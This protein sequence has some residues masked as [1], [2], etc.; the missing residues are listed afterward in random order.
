MVFYNFLTDPLELEDIS[1][2]AGSP[3]YLIE[4]L[5]EELALSSLLAHTVTSAELEASASTSL[6]LS[7]FAFTSAD[8]EASTTNLLVVPSIMIVDELLAS[9]LLYTSPSPRDQ[10]GSR[11][12]SSA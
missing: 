1:L 7:F 5:E 8:E 3:L 11:M 6:A 9:C 4:E 2:L 12:P 10:R